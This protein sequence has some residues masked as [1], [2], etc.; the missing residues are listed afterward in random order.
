M[1]VFRGGYT[2]QFLR[3]NLD[4]LTVRVEETPNVTRWLGPRGWN[5]LVGW[6]EVGAEVG[7]FDPENRIIFSVGPLVGTTAPTAGRTTVSSIMPRG[8]PDPMWSSSSMGGYFGAEM[9][10]A[11]YDGIVIQGQA[12]APCYLLIED[13]KVTLKDA[14]DLWGQ[15]TYITQKALKARHGNRHQIA[16]IGPAGENRVRY[17]CI[18]HRLSNAAGNGGFGGVLGSK[19]LKAI[20][21]RGTGGVRIADPAAFLKATSYVW[22]LVKGGLSYIGQI[23]EGYPVVACTHGCSVKCGARVKSTEDRYDTD[24]LVNMSKCVGN[25]WAGR[26]PE[27]ELTSIRGEKLITAQ[28]PGLGRE[29]LD[30]ESLAESM[31]M[32]AWAYHTWARYFHALRA[33]GI[34][35][36]DGEKLDIDNSAWWRDWILKTSY[37][38]GL[39]ADY[40][41]GLARF[42]DKHQ[43]GPRHIAEFFQS[44]GSRGHEWH[45]EGRTMERHPSPYWEHSALLY[46]VS[47]RDVTP[48]THGFFFLNTLYGYPSAPKKPSEIPA[49]L[50]ELAERVYGSRRAIYPGDEYIEHVTAWHQHRSIIKDSLGLCDWVFPVVR[51]TFETKEDFEREMQAEQGSL[52]GDTSAE[53]AMY[54]PCT[55]IDMDIAEMESPIAERIVNLERC[56]EV[57]NNGRCREVDELVIPHYQ[58]IDKTDG[59]HLSED[60]SEFRALLDR[61]YELRGWDKQTGWP[62]PEKL[63]QLDLAKVAA[64]IANYAPQETGRDATGCVSMRGK[65]QV[66]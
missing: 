62:T 34:D 56:I 49:R 37:R 61:Y 18:T 60:A 63:E 15:G 7:P 36:I 55:G 3:V 65:E 28:A 13:D 27:M 42:Y 58:W 40:A 54:R 14:G 23:E 45:R 51:R 10:Y 52:Y 32:T 64:E 41:D 5:V 9:K 43:V 17:A 59:T 50:Q 19:N 11:G 24:S 21:I 30:L 39:G 8:Y 22:N 33:V 2:G 12:D 31:G 44:A 6:N 1:S 4:N 38:Q 35:E 16:S 46:A 25:C 47:T 57:R 26:I 66:R 48:S 20:V 29:G 53:A